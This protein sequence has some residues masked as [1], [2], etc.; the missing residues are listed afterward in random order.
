M[1]HCS[2]MEINVNFNSSM[3]LVIVFFIKYNK[4]LYFYKNGKMFHA[5]PYFFS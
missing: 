4:H 1:L 5:M 2:N 3:L